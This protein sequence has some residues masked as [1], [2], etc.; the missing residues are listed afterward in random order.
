[1]PDTKYLLSARRSSYNFRLASWRLK[2]VVRVGMLCYCHAVRRTRSS[3]SSI[4]I[5]LISRCI[6][7]VLWLKY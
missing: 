7:L 2:Q 4:L 6:C 3:L 1:M 5:S